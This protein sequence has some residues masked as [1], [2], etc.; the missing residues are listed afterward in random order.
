MVQNIITPIAMKAGQKLASKLGVKFI[1]G[2]GSCIVTSIVG[3]KMNNKL[4]QECQDILS[5]ESLSDEDIIE[6][7]EKA[8]KKTIIKSSLLNGAITMAFGGA[9]I[10]A[11]KAI[12]ASKFI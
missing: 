4:A 8:T 1:S 12:D 11:F 7:R 3:Q 10:G 6:K 5:D 2:F 9:S